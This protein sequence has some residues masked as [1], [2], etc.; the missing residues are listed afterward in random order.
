[1]EKKYF[2]D[3]TDQFKNWMRGLKDK[4]ARALIIKRIE[5]LEL[6]NAGD[7]KAFSGG[8]NEMRIHYGAGY[9]VYWSREG[10]RL[11]I[12]LVGGNKSTQRR[13]IEKA[14]ALIKEIGEG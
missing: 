7:N 10:E 5:R 6:G 14:Y 12:L 9:R 13:D 11:I 4:T 3:Q 8:L 1:M 2:I